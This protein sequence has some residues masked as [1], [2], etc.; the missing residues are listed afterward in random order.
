MR[1]YN[2]AALGEGGHGG[3]LRKV[4]WAIAYVLGVPV[5]LHLVTYAYGVTTDLII[6]WGCR[7]Y[8]L[9]QLCCHSGVQEQSLCAS[10]QPLSWWCPCHTAVTTSL[11]GA[12]YWVHSGQ[13][14]FCRPGRHCP[15]PS[16]FDGIHQIFF[17]TR[18]F[19]LLFFFHEHS[20][21]IC[22]IFFFKGHLKERL[23]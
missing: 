14:R 21:Q 9:G 20:W 8:L 1:A 23:F 7:A 2:T 3:S 4:D 5:E 10:P 17:S 19:Y 22:F 12:P 6:P 13:Q 16:H 11:L 15:A 18:R